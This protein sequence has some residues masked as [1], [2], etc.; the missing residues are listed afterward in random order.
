MLWKLA[1]KELLF[2]RMMSCCQIAAIACILAPLLLLFSL[3][4]GILQEMEVRLKNVP[5][6]RSVSL[7][8]ASRLDDTFLKNLQALPE[9]GYVI[10]EITA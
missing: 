2:D 10:P 8:T 7:D 1:R 5:Q 3:R 4:H 6:V 9:V